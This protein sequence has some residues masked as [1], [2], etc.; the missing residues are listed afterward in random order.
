M[1]EVTAMQKRSCAA[2]GG[3]SI[4]NPSKNALV[5]PFC[6]TTEPLVE[7]D[8][9][10]VEHDLAAAL[11][12]IPD[13][14]RGWQ[15][16]K[17]SVRCQHC[18][19]ISVFDPGTVA[20]RCSF[21]GS[22]QLV[23]YEETKLPFRPESLLPL[24]LSESQA[25]DALR[26]W[27]K[28]VW[29]A[30]NNLSKIS[31]ADTFKGVYLPFWT[32][33]AQAEA[34]W[35]AEAGYYYYTQEEYTDSEGKRRT[36]EVRHIRWERASGHVSHFF[37]DE[38]VPASH[39]ADASLLEKVNPFPT[40]GLIPYDPAYVAGWT[41]EHYQIDLVEAARRSRERMD[42]QLED[43]CEE[44]I[45]GD[46]HRGLQV[47]SEYSEQTFKHILAPVWLVTYVYGARSFQVLINGVTGKMGG[48]YPKSWI[49]ITAAVVSALLLIAIMLLFAL[50]SR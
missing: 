5:C 14:Q 42:Q 49:K 19:A 9:E 16:E 47:H 32:F 45:P 37:D 22:S 43:M 1:A 33:D 39:G 36:R 50:H 13:E 35:R 29:F 4:W 18:R 8:G 21:C 41:V 25:R 31:A 48:R 23:A 7:R 20:Q 10:V 24:K 38:L 3:E 6:G 34:D 11:R 44:C 2:C 17:Q 27:Y 46:T 15:V 12:G 26:A 28:K 40:D 30:P